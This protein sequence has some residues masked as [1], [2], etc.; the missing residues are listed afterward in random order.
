MQQGIDPSRGTKAVAV[1]ARSRACHGVPQSRPG[2]R[3][4]GRRRRRP[5]SA[6]AVGVGTGGGSDPGHVTKLRAVCRTVSW[7]RRV[8]FVRVRTGGLGALSECR[9]VSWPRRV[10]AVRVRTRGLGG[11]LWAAAAQPKGGVLAKA[12]QFGKSP[13][14]RPW[15]TPLWLP[16][17]AAARRRSP[18]RRAGA[19]T[20]GGGVP[21]DGSRRSDRW[22]SGSGRNPRGRRGGRES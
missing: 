4:R 10:K 13:N 20:R 15:R 19:A 2:R 7:P 1:D 9:T 18:N 6:G 5:G 3:A 8:N 11:R 12:R 14:R 17:A 16:W 21:G 22:L